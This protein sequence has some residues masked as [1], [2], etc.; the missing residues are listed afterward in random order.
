MTRLFRNVK[1]LQH[2]IMLE[3]N[4]LPRELFFLVFDMFNVLYFVLYLHEFFPDFIHTYIHTYI[5]DCSSLITEK[6][7]LNS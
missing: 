5:H 4:N 3:Q 2:S 6:D 7:H 1:S